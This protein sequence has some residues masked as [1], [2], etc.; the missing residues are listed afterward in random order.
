[1]KIAFLRGK[2]TLSSSDILR[3]D[4]FE[5]DLQF[6]SIHKA[7]APKNVEL[8]EINWRLGESS[9]DGIDAAI[10]GTTWDYQ[11]DQELFLD[12][13]SWIESKMSLFNS[14]R[15]VQWNIDKRYLKELGEAG[16]ATI[17]TVWTDNCSQDVLNGAFDQLDCNKIV[18]KRQVGAG[19]EGQFSLE[20]GETVPAEV[21]FDRPMMIQPFL[22]SVCDEGEYSFIFVDGAFSHALVKRPATGDYRVQSYFGGCEEAVSPSPADLKAAQAIADYFTQDAPLYARIDMVRGSDN[23]L[24][25]ME[26]EMIEPYLYPVE[27]PGL[28]EKM[29]EAL[30]KRLG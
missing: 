12:K 1:M 22:Q 29:A 9:F 7:L 8:V 26:A 17:P 23:N 5:H 14:V 3:S 18:V 4:A 10:I 15:T 20:R 28:G 2:S 19:A 11:D 21:S 24:V 25:L 27:G 16:A 30:M 6:A 13:L